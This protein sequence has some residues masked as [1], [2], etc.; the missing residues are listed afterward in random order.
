MKGFLDLPLRRLAISAFLL[1]ALWE[2]GQC[3]MLYDM[4]GWGVL[5]GSIWMWAAIIGDVMI[6]AGIVWAAYLI[7]GIRHLNP[8][9]GLGWAVLVT[10]SFMAGVTLEWIALY[11]RLW[12]YSPWMPTIEVIGY[13][14]G[15]SPI[16]QVTV[17]PP[18]SLW[19]AFRYAVTVNEGQRL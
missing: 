19:L 9:D 8:P 12:G 13:S 6:V 5:R 4:W 7:L 11:V 15:I 18:L 1:N 10:A 17:L 16:A 14:V 3:T 2:F